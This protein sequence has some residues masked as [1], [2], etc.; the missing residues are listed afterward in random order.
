MWTNAQYDIKT[1]FNGIRCNTSEPEGYARQCWKS[2]CNRCQ[3]VKAFHLQRSASIAI[4]W[5]VLGEEWSNILIFDDMDGMWYWTKAAFIQHNTTVYCN[6][7]LPL[8]EDNN[9]LTWPRTPLDRH[10][11]FSEVAVPVSEVAMLAEED[12]DFFCMRW[13]CTLH[14]VINI[15]IY[16]VNALCVFLLGSLFFFM[17]IN[18]K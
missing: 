15:N 8:P 17:I 1:N 14:I 3:K 18:I 13:W 12:F 4:Q 7:N 2:L 16:I 6:T 5:P 11:N 9:I 10:L